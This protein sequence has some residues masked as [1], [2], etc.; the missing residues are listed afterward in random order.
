[1][2]HFNRTLYNYLKYNK[3]P[4]KSEKNYKNNFKKIDSLINKSIP[5]EMKDEFHINFESNSLKE[6]LIFTIEKNF[7]QY[8]NIS[9]YLK[10]NQINYGI[11]NMHNSKDLSLKLDKSDR[12]YREPFDRIN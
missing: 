1:M 5:K 6:L 12:L 11:F 4:F 8:L 9:N 7:I 3:K 10:L 2:N